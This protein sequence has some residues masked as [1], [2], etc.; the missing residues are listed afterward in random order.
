[1]HHRHV[2]PATLDLGRTVRDLGPGVTRWPFLIGIGGLVVAVVLAL[3]RAAVVGDGGS[4]ERLMF[5]YLQNFFYFLTI[6]WGALFFVLVSHLTRA[7]WSVTVRRI[8]EVMAATIWPYFALMFLPIL[9]CV[10]LSPGLVYSWTDA[11]FV[12]S[13]PVVE[14]KTP[15]LN[16]TFFTIRAVIYFASWALLAGWF[17]RD[18]LRQ[19]ETGEAAISKRFEGR[20]AW[21]TLI[22]FLTVTF[23]AVDWVMSLAPEWYS[24]MFGVYVIAG[25]MLSFFAALWLIVAAMQSRGV[26]RDVVTVEHQHDIGKY[27][28]GF[29]IFWGYITFCQFLLIWYGDIP[30][31]THWFLDRQYGGWHWIGILIILAHFVIP[32]F[33]TMSRHVKR[34]RKAMLFWCVWIVAMHWFD[35]AYM[36]LPEAQP[37]LLPGYHS[38][39]VDGTGETISAAA[40]LLNLLMDLSMLVGVGGLT[41]SGFVRTAAGHALVPL[42]DPRLEESLAFHNV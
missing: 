34:N 6:M 31:E 15:Y 38:Y 8:A 18:S 17:Y 30:E 28:F 9:A 7:G 29:I 14:H 11:E 13:H 40:S 33:G 22:V 4:L 35:V 16:A 41:V 12:A 26:L 21:G 23:A 24:T 1:M 2:D 27:I 25:S 19:D 5:A 3:V 42:K 36:I 20:S 37:A 39:S 32:F 10:W